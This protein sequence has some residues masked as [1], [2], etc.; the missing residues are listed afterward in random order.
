ML[1]NLMFC[2]NATVPLFALMILGYWFVRIG[3]LK[4][5]TLDNINTFV[6]KVSLP[7]MVFLDLAQTNFFEV[8]DGKYVAF[9]FLATLASVII[10]SLM[11]KLFDK[12]IRGEFA[13]AAYRSSAAILGVGFIESIYG[14]SAMAPLMMIGTV[15]LYNVMAVLI[16]MLTK[17]G[18]EEGKFDAARFKKTVIGVIKN[19]IIL[20]IIIGVL[21]SVLKV[22]MPTMAYKTFK[23]L[24]N[25]ATPLGLIVIGGSFD[26][27]KA[28]NLVKP[29]FLA[30][31]M[32]LIGW[33]LIY[34]PI[35]IALGFRN[36]KLIAALI[37]MGSPTTVTAFVMA[38]N[39]G[40]DGTLSASV[41]ML[42]CAFCIFT[43]TGWLFVLRTLGYV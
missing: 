6:F 16:L 4:E 12:S 3:L 9:C 24:S 11:S 1:S 25:T 7:V 10:A 36:D 27:K 8:W 17:P 15:P 22:P 18:D 23:Y 21:W 32:K 33:G 19:P 29:A 39:M 41:V 34:M 13:Q 26:F 40:H 38:K 35:A 28:F 5:K 43:L 14:T 30:T 31:F 20:G 2:L 37:M 42:A